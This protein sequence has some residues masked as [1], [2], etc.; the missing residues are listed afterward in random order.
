MIEPSF[1]R[2]ASFRTRDTQSRTT[3]PRTPTLADSKTHFATPYSDNFK[4]GSFFNVTQSVGS[5]QHSELPSI[6]PPTSLNSTYVQSHV[7][8]RAKIE[9]AKFSHM[10]N[11]INPQSQSINSKREVSNISNEMYGQEVKSGQKEFPT[12][13]LQRDQSDG[14]AHLDKDEDTISAGFDNV[15]EK[16]IIDQCRIIHTYSDTSTQQTQQTQQLVPKEDAL[17]ARLLNNSRSS[18]YLH[19]TQGLESCY[20]RKM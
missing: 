12:S 11:L 7:S 19:M 4:A 10:S 20:H 13:I 3:G 2:T 9:G 8:P 15:F 1:T 17:L 5:A 16:K 14:D 6:V 18:K